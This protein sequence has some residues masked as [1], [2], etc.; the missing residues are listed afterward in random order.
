[1]FTWVNLAETGP[2]VIDVPAGLIAGFVSDIWQRAP[3]DIGVPGKFAGKGAKR[4]L[5]GP[6][7][8][9]PKDAAGYDIIQTESN[10]N[11]ILIRIIDPKPEVANL[12]PPDSLFLSI[13]AT[14]MTYLLFSSNLLKNI[15]CQSQNRKGHSWQ[16]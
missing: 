1:M 2:V 8:D 11:L 7:Q 13:A 3:A 14:S 6:G 10:H 5:L 15:G 16:I 12:S 4:I 9:V